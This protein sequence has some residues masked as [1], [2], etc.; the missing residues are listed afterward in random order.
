MSP[1]TT[2]EENRE[3]SGGGSKW[4]YVEVEVGIR[5]DRWTV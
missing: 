4:T 3:L 2:L 1:T 5:S